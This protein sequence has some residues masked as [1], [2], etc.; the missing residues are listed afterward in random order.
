[1]SADAISDDDWLDDEAKAI[2][3]RRAVRERLTVVS[4][5]GDLRMNENTGQWDIY[6]GGRWL[7][8][9]RAEI[10]GLDWPALLEGDVGDD[11][12][13]NTP[14]NVP[15]RPFVWK[16]PASLPRREWLYG[17]HYIRK[18]VSAT[19]APGGLGKSS[20]AVVEALAMVSGKALLGSRPSKALRVAYW[21]GED[22]HDENDRRI[23][24]AALHYGL[25]PDDIGDRLHTGSGRDAPIVMAEQTQGG[26]VILRPNVE[27]VADAIRTMGLDVV[28][29]DP[30]V[31]SHRVSEN[32]NNA[33]DSVVK[34]WARIADRFNISL[35]LVHHTRKANGAET[36]VED[37]RG[38][39]A[40]L[41][42]V[43]SA[44]ALN[45]MSEEEAAKAGVEN[46]FEY[47][48]ADNGKANMAPRSDKATWH[49]MIGVDLGNGGDAPGDHVGV[50][51]SWTWPDPFEDVTANDLFAVQK[52][53][54]GGQWRENPQASE[55]AGKAVAEVLSLDL[56]DKGAKSKVKGLLAT[57]LKSG[58]LVR[59]VGTDEGR[60]E[61][62][63]I[64]VGKWAEIG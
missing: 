30:F 49:R 31:S 2:L 10:E 64:E 12:A 1:M 13:M 36:T 39:S 42:A 57:W 37:G 38:A 21:S 58:A 22:P 43:R 28:I 9:E 20:L 54:D 53:I 7:T 16:D 29:I 55:W 8:R 23:M 51:T 18:F 27:A 35:D 59:V 33:V 11:G 40:L 6:T 50:V 25:T 60:R 63:M 56:E 48:R 61:R 4:G 5:D 46:R 34:E 41:Y 19:F 3:A 44:R 14:L 15:F 45:G 52:A 62:P 26:T 17:R 24:A 47:F 32:D